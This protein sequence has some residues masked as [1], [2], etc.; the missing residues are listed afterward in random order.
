MNQIIIDAEFQS[1]II[2]LN[3]LERSNLEGNLTAYGC[4]TPLVV[5]NGEN[6]LLDGHNRREICEAYGI[7]FSVV[8]IELPDRD[9]ALDWIDRNQLGRRNLPPDQMAL[10]RGR[11]YNRAKARQGGTGANQ[12]TEQ[13]PQ[14]DGSANT[15]KRLSEEFGVSKA[16]IERDGQFAS[17]VETLK[18]IDPDIEREI[19]SGEHTKANVVKAARQVTANP[20]EPEKALEIL[21]PVQPVEE[22]TPPRPVPNGPKKGL[23]LAHEA[24]GVLRRIPRDDQFRARGFQIVEDWITQAKKRDAHEE[25]NSLHQ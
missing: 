3:T 4:L 2:P 12:H 21:R 16:T 13:K 24:I 19:V 20:A 23:E 6:I 22:P 14:N 5:W 9:S 8:E 18:A 25:A 1:R 11:V 10:L 7:P 17:A 15:A